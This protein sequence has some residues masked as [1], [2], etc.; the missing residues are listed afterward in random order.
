MRSSK[1]LNLVGDPCP[2]L[3]E[4]TLVTFYYFAAY[5][6]FNFE[7]LSGAPVLVRG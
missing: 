6:I 2:N 4:T 5:A 3:V 1:Y 7:S